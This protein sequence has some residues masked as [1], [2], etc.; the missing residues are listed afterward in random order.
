MSLIKKSDV[1]NHLSPRFR[2]KIHLCQ[3]DATGF[4]VAEP[5]AIKA[6]PASFAGDF[7]AEHSSS[8]VAVA[9]TDPATGSIRPQTPTASKSALA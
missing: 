9:P 7:V 5:D 8:G 1:K 6:N 2:T 4:S 3:P